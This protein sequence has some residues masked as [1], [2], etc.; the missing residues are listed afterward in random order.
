MLPFRV[1][2]QDGLP[3]SD[4]LVRSAQRAI[5]SGELAA[6]ARFPS[7]RVL[8]QE[9]RISPT[10]AHKVV[11]EL[12]AAGCLVSRP[13]IGM[14]VVSAAGPPR[15][16]LQ[17]RLR[18]SCEQLLCEAEQLGLSAE[19]TVELIKEIAAKNKAHESKTTLKL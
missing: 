14:V 17:E 2:I 16:S 18:P 8:A 6:G 11:L 5:A 9:L 15:E 13:G 12:K 19:E 4:Q 10:T 3:V 1:Q 7:V